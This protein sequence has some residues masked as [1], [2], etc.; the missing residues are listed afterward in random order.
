MCVSI[1]VCVVGEYKA[2]KGYVV[3]SAGFYIPQDL[4][5]DTSYQL[6]LLVSEVVSFAHNT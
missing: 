1:C 4:T 6:Q 5:A 3:P 2:Y